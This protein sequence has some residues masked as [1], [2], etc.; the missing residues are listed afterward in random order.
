VEE[1]QSGGGGG[2]IEGKRTMYVQRGYDKLFEE[3][4][5]KLRS[6]AQGF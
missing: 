2:V 5:P 1:D 3:S 6:T 4:E